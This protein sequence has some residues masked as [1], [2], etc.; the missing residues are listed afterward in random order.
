MCVAGADPPSPPL[1]F[2]SEIED[3]IAKERQERNNAASLRESEMKQD[4]EA[5][6]AKFHA[7]RKASNEAAQAKNLC[8]PALLAQCPLSGAGLPTADGSTATSEASFSAA[9]T[10]L[11]AWLDCRAD[12][13]AAAEALASETNPWNTVYGMVEQQ[14]ATMAGASQ[15]HNDV[16]L[17]L[18]EKGRV[19]MEA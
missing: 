12:E 5:A 13:Q 11:F 15:Q 16:L 18:N 8:A 7:D 10:R 2:R 1:I 3:K 6:L 4:A 9:L 19:G 17:N 14:V